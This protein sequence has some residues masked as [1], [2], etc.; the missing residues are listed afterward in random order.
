M[1]ENNLENN[2]F[3]T[4]SLL[5]LA[6]VAIGFTLSFTKPIMIP[7]VMALLIRILIDP[8]I[9]FQIDNLHVHRIIAVF[10]SLLLI[11]FIFIIIV[12][13]L[14]ASVATFLQSADD[15]NSKVLILI[16]LLISELQKYN[17]QVD[18]EVIRNTLINLPFLD[19]AST[20][21]SNSANFLS[22]FFLV[23]IMTLFLLLGKKSR[24][25]SPEWNEIIAHVKKY[26]FTIFFKMGLTNING[27]FF[28]SLTS[29]TTI[30]LWILT[31]V[32]ARPMPEP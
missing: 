30:L 22:K 25:T 6:L 4:F 32:A 10:V 26:I 29:T 14:V 28:P 16:D 17:V 27:L 11:V 20:L 5:I 12:P 9:D 1:S 3:I 7:F 8:I 13:F 31:C 18:R 21:L 19:W 23:V 15:Y 24:N 2:K